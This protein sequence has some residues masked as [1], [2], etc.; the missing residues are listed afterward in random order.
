M[1]QTIPDHLA[2]LPALVTPEILA[3]KLGI[4]TQSIYQRI[5]RHKKNPDL[6]LL[7][8]VVKIPGS[9]RVAFTRQSII[10]WWLRAN[11]DQIQ[12]DYDPVMEKRVGRPTIA[13]QIAARG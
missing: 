12:L 8:P 11:P 3:E 9:N 2:D 10:V 1:A 5:W 6:N 13:Q 7:P 4:K